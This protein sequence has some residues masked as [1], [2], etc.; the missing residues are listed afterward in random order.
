ML[1]GQPH[2]GLFHLAQ[3]SSDSNLQHVIRRGLRKCGLR[4]GGL[5]HGGLQRPHGAG[6]M[7]KL[8]LAH[9]RH[10]HCALNLVP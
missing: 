4:H 3:R 7:L 1:Q 10:D 6:N 5:L 9:G 2:V 8:D